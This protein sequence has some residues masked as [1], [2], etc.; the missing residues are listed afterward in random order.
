MVE[1]RAVKAESKQLPRQILGHMRSFVK[2][3][4]LFSILNSH[5][6]PS[7]LARI[8]FLNTLLTIFY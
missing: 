3:N 1:K 2:P 8:Y 5:F 7:S 4:S 6:S